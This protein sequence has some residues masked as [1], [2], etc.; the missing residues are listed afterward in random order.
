MITLTDRALEVIGE[1]RARVPQTEW[2]LHI[3][4]GAGEADNFRLPNGRQGWTRGIPNGW[5]V[6]V[7]PYTTESE[8]RFTLSLVSGVNVFLDEKA[9][10]N[11]P[12][13]GGVVDAN[14]IDLY[15]AP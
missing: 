15:I 7:Q 11:F 2:C 1:Y 13:R 14:G 6:S 3:A 10:T 8:G 9:P 12:F 4:W 5:L